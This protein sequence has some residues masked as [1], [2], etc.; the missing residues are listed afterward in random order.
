MT[1]KTTLDREKI[2][3]QVAET[4]SGLS[5]REKLD[6]NSIKEYEYKMKKL[7]EDN[8]LDSLA[9]KSHAAVRNIQSFIVGLSITPLAIVL[10][11]H[12]ITTDIA[13]PW[14][15][16]VV[17]GYGAMGYYAMKYS[18]AQ[19]QSADALAESH[20]VMEASQFVCDNDEEVCAL[21]LESR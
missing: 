9:E 4:M 13:L 11:S 18:Q 7:H 10:L 21:A 20:T 12:K 16:G 17:L 1:K 2:F 14:C 19:K 8:K 5:T 3:E 15:A 6:F